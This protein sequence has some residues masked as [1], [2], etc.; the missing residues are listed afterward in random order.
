MQIDSH[1]VAILWLQGRVPRAG[2]HHQ[3]VHARGHGHRPQVARRVC[4]EVLQVQRPDTAQQSQE[5]AE[6]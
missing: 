4:S 2:A 6:D 3:G 5:I 1:V